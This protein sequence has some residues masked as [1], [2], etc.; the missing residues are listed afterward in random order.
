METPRPH[1]PLITPYDT[2]APIPKS[3][4]SLYSQPQGL[5][6]MVLS[7]YMYLHLNYKS[8]HRSNYFFIQCMNSS[9]VELPVVN[10][11]CTYTVTFSSWSI[12]RWTKFPQ[13]FVVEWIIGSQRSTR[14]SSFV[15]EL[16]IPDS[17]HQ[18]E[19]AKQS[20]DCG[21]ILIDC[22]WVNWSF[23]DVLFVRRC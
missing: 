13:P 11:T 7:I 18:L 8:F 17:D 20:N 14:Q 22:L 1:G 15:P 23:S 21:H 12:C 16:T 19:R 4:R 3:G 10:W 2:T 5:T 6:P 9:S